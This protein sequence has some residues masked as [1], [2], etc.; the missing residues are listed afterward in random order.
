MSRSDP[1]YWEITIFDSS[2]PKHR[3]VFS[4]IW[5]SL[6]VVLFCLAIYRVV[7]HPPID[8][9]ELFEG[10]ALFGVILFVS[11]LVSAGLWS[12]PLFSRSPLLLVLSVF[13]WCLILYRV[14]M[15]SPIDYFALF[16]NLGAFAYSLF[17]SMKARAR[18]RNKPT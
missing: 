1:K 6:V 14:V 8:Y 12:K 4:I 2:N 10:T 9:F 18:E 3:R 5:Y 16:G 7:M 11:I 15:H 17:I 13:L